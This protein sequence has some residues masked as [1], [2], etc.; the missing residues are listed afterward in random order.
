MSKQKKSNKL[1]LQKTDLVL[2]KKS[3]ETKNTEIYGNL[4]ECL[5]IYDTLS[6]NQ[7]KQDIAFDEK[8]R[9]CLLHDIRGMMSHVKKE[10]Y[11]KSSFEVA[12]KEMHCQLCGRK[13]VYICYIKN[14]IN[15]EVLLISQ[16]VTN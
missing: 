9:W 5:K 15:G 13:N 11:A 10:W 8:A 6:Q 1:I 7:L 3:E 16:L 2:I 14:R 12:D 4:Y